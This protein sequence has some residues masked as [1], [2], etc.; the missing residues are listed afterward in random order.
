MRRGFTLIELLVVIAVVALLI[1]L[2]LPA[3]AS[4]RES[5]RATVCLANLRGI[6]D[7]CRAYADV[8]RGYSP[9]LGQP[10]T[11]LPNWA[12]VVQAG[13][14]LGG[15]TA[16]ELF[17][18]RSALI[19]P[20]VRAYYG[21]GMQRTY[22]INVTG[23]GGLPGDPDSYDVPGRPS[24]IR[25]DLVDRPWERVLV[26]DSSLPP[27]TPD[28]PPPTRTSSV[29]DFR[30]TA[31][32]AERVGRFHAGR[33]FIQGVAFDGS[34]RSYPDVPEAWREPLP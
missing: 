5:G 16:N 13:S 27:P 17:T 19:C 6:H 9:A 26:I 21:S 24:H 20:T 31:H 34:A 12:L 4:A 8:S 33:G 18:T 29:I 23:H 32:L 15:A 10:Y 25:M 28:A 3:L 2:L 14:G 7:A 22:G 1:G 11:E 30:L